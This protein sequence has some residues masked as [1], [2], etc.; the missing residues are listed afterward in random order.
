[1]LIV[2]TFIETSHFVEA[3]KRFTFTHS[4]ALSN[5]C[6]R[7]GAPRGRPPF[8][9]R[10]RRRTG[11]R[12]CRGRPVICATT[13]VLFSAAPLSR[14]CMFITNVYHRQTDKCP[15][16]RILICLRA[17]TAFL[18][19]ASAQDASWPYRLLQSGESSVQTLPNDL[20]RCSSA[21]VWHCSSTVCRRAAASLCW[22]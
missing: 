13:S 16:S 20:R 7:R 11:P 5:H 18:P 15:H 19:R 10:W 9:G 8:C 6:W 1:M 4:S 14:E 17:A 21:A 2:T 12:G 22:D 3:Y